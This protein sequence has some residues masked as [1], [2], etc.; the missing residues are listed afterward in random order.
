M[1]IKELIE[2]WESSGLLEGMTKNKERDEL[3]RLLENSVRYLID[4]KD[5]DEISEEI[6]AVMLPCIRRIYD[7]DN[8]IAFD[9][10]FLHE[11]LAHC[12]SDMNASASVHAIDAEA[13]ATSLACDY[14]VKKHGV[15]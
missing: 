12:L 8:S 11:I 9:F 6:C 10:K 2:R 13:E 15:R 3:S 5:K 1:K 7:I 4:A 14:Y